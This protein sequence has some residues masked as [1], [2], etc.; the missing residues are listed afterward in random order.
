MSFKKPEQPAQ[1]ARSSSN[2]R[3]EFAE[4][5]EASKHLEPRRSR[6][7][8]ICSEPRDDTF[9]IWKFIVI[10]VRLVGE[11]GATIQ[12]SVSLLC[13][14]AKISLALDYIEHSKYLN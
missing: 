8:P 6:K 7:E 14:K 1:V 2:Y 12:N 5:D 11:T 9:L 10:E 4:I 3:Y 13:R